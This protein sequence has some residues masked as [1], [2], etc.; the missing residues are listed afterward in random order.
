MSSRKKLSIWLVAIISVS[1][2]VGIILANVFAAAT[3]TIRSGFKVSY[4]VDSNV[5]AE[6]SG[7]YCKMAKLGNE[8]ELTDGILGSY[9]GSTIGGADRKIE[10]TGTE[11]D[12]QEETLGSHTANEIKFSAE[13]DAL[14]FEFTFINKS[15]TSLSAKLSINMLPTNTTLTYYDVDAEEWKSVS[16]DAILTVS[17]VVTPGSKETKVIYVQLAVEDLTQNVAVSS[18]ELSW[19]L[20]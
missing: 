17:G 5:K 9:T 8:L 11:T 20:Q 4:T 7:K 1:I 15:L 14:V 16:S 6:V 18:F 3:Q 13:E 12:D 2:V 10:F 19:T